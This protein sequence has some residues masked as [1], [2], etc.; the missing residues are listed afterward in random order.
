[1]TRESHSLRNFTAFIPTDIIYIAHIMSHPKLPSLS[2]IVGNSDVFDERNALTSALSTLFEPSPILLAKLVPE[3]HPKLHQ[4]SERP[5]PLTYNSLIDFAR[6]TISLWSIEDQASFVGAHPR[7]GEVS[8]LSALSASEQAARATPPEV[9]ERLKVLN[10]AYER[11]FEGLRY[12]TFVNGRSRKEV[13]QE[14]QEVLGVGN[15]TFGLEDIGKVKQGDEEYLTEC[16]R[17]VEDV[18]KI[19]KSRLSALGVDGDVAFLEA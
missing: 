17:A 11:K 3:L 4:P 5:T 7:I 8:N 10:E 19:A 18:A 12:I 15:K 14:M 2:Q 1:M 16:R 13:M 9:L 6:D